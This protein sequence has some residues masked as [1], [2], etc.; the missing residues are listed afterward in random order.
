MKNW[1]LFPLAGDVEGKKKRK[2][3]WLFVI[4]KITKCSHFYV[5][6][7]NNESVE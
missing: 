6:E 7:N 3:M 1:I 2:K 5:I 4:T